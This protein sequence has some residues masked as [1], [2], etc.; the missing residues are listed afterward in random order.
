VVSRKQYVHPQETSDTT[1]PHHMGL[2]RLQLPPNR[3]AP[4]HGPSLYTDQPGISL[5]PQTTAT[6]TQEIDNNIRIY[7]RL[8]RSNKTCAPLGIKA[9]LSH[10]C[11]HQNATTHVR[12][13]WPL[14]DPKSQQL[15][16]SI[17]VGRWEWGCNLKF[18][19]RVYV[20]GSWSIMGQELATVTCTY[21]TWSMG[22]AG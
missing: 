6:A 3:A 14:V 18:N 11:I 16:I 1:V 5:W 9:W 17:D 7:L 15:S 20:Y 10:L 12:S 4:G 22:G 21:V 2:T 13:A 19:E 8:S